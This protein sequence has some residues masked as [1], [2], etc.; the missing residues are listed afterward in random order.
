MIWLTNDTIETFERMYKIDQHPQFIK[1][2]IFLIIRLV[3]KGL[4]EVG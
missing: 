1:C 2:I 4:E 3:D